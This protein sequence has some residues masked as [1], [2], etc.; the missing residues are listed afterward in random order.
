MEAAFDA[1]LKHLVA[2]RNIIIKPVFVDLLKIGPL[3]SRILNSKWS[4]QMLFLVLLSINS[5]KQ[6]P[7]PMI[8]K[9]FSSHSKPRKPVAGPGYFNAISLFLLVKVVDKLNKFCIRE[10]GLK[11]TQCLCRLIA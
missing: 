6:N 4:R 8:E 7:F 1:D 3:F 5:Q 11:S 10:T 2:N 9:I